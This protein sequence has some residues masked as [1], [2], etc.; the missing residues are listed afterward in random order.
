MGSTH[1]SIQ[2]WRQEDLPAWQ[3]V[4]QELRATVMTWQNWGVMAA[5]LSPYRP[6]V[7]PVVTLKNLCSS[8]QPRCTFTHPA[9]LTQGPRQ[10]PT[11]SWWL[12]LESACVQSDLQN[13]VSSLP[14]SQPRARCP[15]AEV[16]HAITFLC[17]FPDFP[18]LGDKEIE[19][20]SDWMS[21]L[22]THVKSQVRI[23][24]GFSYHHELPLCSQAIF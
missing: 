11:S 23:W 7:M 19:A 15:S 16:N 6:G 1:P 4:F 10:V 3:P 18:H 14:P 8:W 13:C 20:P 21:F 9:A 2:G 12:T 17:L 24:T 5:A 22:R